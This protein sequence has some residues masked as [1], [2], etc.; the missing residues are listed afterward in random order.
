LTPRKSLIHFDEA[1]FLG[2]M[3]NE[4]ENSELIYTA[5]FAGLWGVMEVTVG[6]I[7]H[8]SRLPFRGT[9]LTI[10]AVV[11]ITIARSFINYRGSI[12]ALCTAAATIKL[13]TLPGFNITP[14]IAIMMEGLIGE[15]VFTL[16]KYNLWSCVVAG[17]SIMIYTLLHSL[18]MQGVFFGMG[19]Y[20]VYIDLMNSVGKGLNYEGEMSYIMIPVIIVL[21]IIVGGAAGIF[22]WKTANR[23]KEILAAE[24]V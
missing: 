10:A 5:L 9:L 21:Y 2:D 4:T 19:I 8:A 22:G 15:A 16:L 6:T 20:N 17:S 14:F 3:K 12:L 24:G 7:L 23:S 13:I 1:L 18:I 11:I